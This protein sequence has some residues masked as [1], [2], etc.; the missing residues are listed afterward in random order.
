MFVKSANLESHV[1]SVHKKKLKAK[2]QAAESGEVSEKKSRGGSSVGFPWKWVGVSAVVLIVILAVVIIKP[3]LPSGSNSNLPEECVQGK[4]LVVSF[5]WRLHVHY[6]NLNLPTPV[7]NYTHPIPH[8]IGTE[9]IGDQECTRRMYSGSSSEYDSS[10]EPAIIHVGS[11][12]AGDTFY[13]ID[14]FK[15]W[16]Q[17]LNSTPGHKSVMSYGEP[18]WTITLTVNGNPPPTD[19]WE[20]IQLTQGRLFDFYVYQY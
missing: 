10:S 13:L 1:K 14:W 5:T 15:Q 12:D 3:G 18:P 8:G 2:P 20:E 6:T 19:R 4:T 16:G 17:E 11:P 9:P 7:Q